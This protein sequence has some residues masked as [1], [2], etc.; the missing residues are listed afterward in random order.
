MIAK[1]LT[2]SLLR[3]YLDVRRNLHACSEFHIA[4]F[5][6]GSSFRLRLWLSRTGIQVRGGLKSDNFSYLGVGNVE[7][8]KNAHVFWFHP[9][10]ARRDRSKRRGADHQ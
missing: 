4:S 2:A 6:R 5:F 7:V 9:G 1:S 8:H 10:P 3:G